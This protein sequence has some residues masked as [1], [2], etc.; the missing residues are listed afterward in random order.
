M[1]NT[2]Y[3]KLRTEIAKLNM[4]LQLVHYENLNLMEHLGGLN[5][6]EVVDAYNLKMEELLKWD[7]NGDKDE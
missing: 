5:A 1:D 6:Q 4:M 3:L 2:E 7:P